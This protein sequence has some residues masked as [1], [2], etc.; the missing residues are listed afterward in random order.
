MNDFV[1][2]C[3]FNVL[4]LNIYII[5]ELLHIYLEEVTMETTYGGTSYLEKI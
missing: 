3:M 5:S 2:V 4:S 1:V